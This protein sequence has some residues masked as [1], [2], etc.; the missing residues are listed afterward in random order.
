MEELIASVEIA[1]VKPVVSDDGVDAIAGSVDMVGG[2]LSDVSVLRVG[3][4]MG[5]GVESLLELANLTLLR[6][7]GAVILHTG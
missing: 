7:T 1:W 2:K 6:T 3:E 5:A 4:D